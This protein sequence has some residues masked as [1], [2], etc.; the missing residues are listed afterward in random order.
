MSEVIVIGF[1][2]EGATGRK[3]IRFVKSIPV[4]EANFIMQ[5]C[6]VW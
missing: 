1:Q 5:L 3:R 6:I 2:K 4:V